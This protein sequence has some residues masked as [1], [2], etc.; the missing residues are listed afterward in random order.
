VVK[1][2]KLSGAESVYSPYAVTWKAVGTSA[3]AAF[4]VGVRGG[5]Y[6]LRLDDVRL[7]AT[8]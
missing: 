6:E 3:T 8:P 1:S 5:Y 7:S 4:D 2:A